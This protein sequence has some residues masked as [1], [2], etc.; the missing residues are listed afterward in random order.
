MFVPQAPSPTSGSVMYLQADHVRM[1]NIATKQA[2]SVAK[3]IGIGSDEMLR[4]K[5]LTPP[6]GSPK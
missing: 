5:D 2:K 4:G 3:H 1:L 6:A